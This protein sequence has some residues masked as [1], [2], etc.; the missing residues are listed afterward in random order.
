MLYKPDWD[1]AGKRFEAFWENEIVDRCCLAVTAPKAG[2]D[3]SKYFE[4]YDVERFQDTD[5][6]SIKAWWCDPEENL[7]RNEFIF[8]NTFY[9]GEALPIAF[10][11]WGAMVMCAF[12]GSEPIFNKKSVWYP[13]VIHDWEN[14][15]WYFDKQTNEYW[16]IT[17]Q[18]TEAFASA[19]PGRFFA[20]LPELG[21]AGDLLSLLRGMDDLC[22]DLYDYPQ[23]VK[24]GIWELT[25][26]FINLQDELYEIVKH[27]NLG[28]GVLPWMSLWMPGKHGNQLACDFSWVISNHFFREFFMEEILR[29]SAWSEYGTYHLDGPMCMHNHLDTLLEIDSIKAIE[30]TP[31]V[32]SLPTW[33]SDYI[34]HY[35]KIQKKG[36]KLI[37]LAE[38]HE[39]EPI[40]TGLSPRG[41]FIKTQADSEADAKALLRLAENLCTRR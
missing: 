31:G 37:L 17:K 7:K 6:D 2:S 26:T 4:K 15:C 1:K 23:H 25:D 36:K 27:S 29:E 20:G 11:N 9:G 19:A 30:W 13:R 28:G 18:M 39:V 32:G 5:G 10:T 16:R 8:A 12:F 38:P 40:L 3:W 21:S 35:K 24:K 14:W 34:T 41:L 22:L 33:H